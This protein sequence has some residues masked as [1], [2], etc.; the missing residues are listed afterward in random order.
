MLAYDEDGGYN[1]T[2]YRITK[3][4]TNGRILFNSQPTL[5]DP[6]AT[7][8]PTRASTPQ[9]IYTTIRMTALL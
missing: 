6:F 7:D 1:L 5:A 4:P 3:M 2:Q 9:V 8:N